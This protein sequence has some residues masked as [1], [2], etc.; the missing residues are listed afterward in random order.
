M[1]ARSFDRD[2]KNT[3]SLPAGQRAHRDTVRQSEVIRRQFESPC[4]GVWSLVGNG[5][6]N[7]TFIKARDGVIAIDTGE[8]IEEMREALRELRAVEQAPIVGV[9]YTHF[10]YVDGTAAILE[11]SGGAGT[12]GGAATRANVAGAILPIVGH[13]RIATNRTRASAEIGPAYSRGLVEQFAIAL[14]A[15]GPDGLVNVGLGR[16]YRNPAHAP[17]TSGHL[18]VTQELDDSTGTFTLAGETI[19]WAHCPSDSDDSVNFFFAS[20]GLCVHNTVWPVLFN[21]YAIRG[22]EY[23]DPRVLLR[24]FDQVLAWEPEHL[25][26]AHG[27][28]ISG[29]KQIRE[30]VTRSRDAI[31]FLWDQTVRGINKGWTADEIADRVKLPAGCDDDYL[32]SELYGVAEHHVRQIFAGLR[33]WFDGDESKLFP[34][35]PAERYQRLIDGFGGRSKVREQSARALDNNDVRWATELATWLARTTDATADD[36]ALLARCMRTIG[37]RTPAANIRNWALTRARH[38]DGSGPMDR[39]YQHRFSA[40]LVQHHDNATI[41]NTLRVTLEPSLVEGI[42]HLA[43]FVVDGERLS[44]HVRNGVAVPTRVSTSGASSSEATLTRNTLIDVLS[45]RTTWSECVQRGS[46]VVS[47]DSTTLNLVRSAFDVPG[48]RS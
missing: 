6:S 22:E 8:S 39:Y 4:D 43:A 20:R 37:E 33:G 48:L 31:Q 21:V 38:L 12:S 13:K 42:D 47:G 27:P 29:K 10:H 11:E 28:A 45:G 26:G 30:R 18:P 17:F 1:M 15:D 24:G 16:W 46:I 41:I 25:I 2:P 35:E 3:V 36:K 9:I 19:E 7:Q 34:M 14:P 23:R 5:L 40:R 32:T 44:L